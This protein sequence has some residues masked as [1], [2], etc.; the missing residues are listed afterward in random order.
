[1]SEDEILGSV[2]DSAL[3]EWFCHG[4]E[5]YELRRSQLNE[6]ACEHGLTLY[7][8]FLDIPFDMMVDKWKDSYEKDRPSK[9]ES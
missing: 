2:M 5:T 7:S 1:M 4:R 8:T 6:I 9:S 3:N